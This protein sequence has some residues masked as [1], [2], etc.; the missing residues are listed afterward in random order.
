MPTENTETADDDTGDAGGAHAASDENGAQA[1]IQRAFRML[2]DLDADFRAGTAKLERKHSKGF[3]CFF[4]VMYAAIVAIEEG[5]EKETF[6]A[7]H[8][9]RVHGNVKNPYFPMVRAFADSTCALLQG[10]LC[11]KAQVIQLARMQDVKPAEFPNWRKR[12]PVEAACEKLRSLSNSPH[13]QKK[14]NDS[15]PKLDTRG[16]TGEHPVLVQFSPEGRRHRLIRL[17]SNDDLLKYAEHGQHV[18]SNNA[19]PS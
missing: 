11:K 15:E 12:W 5:G 16:L 4:N 18:D 6:L 8:G 7:S 9:I 10:Q 3:D 13:H 17:L 1:L 2:G 19:K 14:Q